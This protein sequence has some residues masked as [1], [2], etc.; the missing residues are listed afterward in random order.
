MEALEADLRGFEWRVL[1]ERS[2]GQ[3]TYA[4]TNLARPPVAWCFHKDGPHPGLRRPDGI[5][6][7]DTTERRYLGPFPGPDPGPPNGDRA[8][9]GST[10]RT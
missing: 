6:L 3:E 9:T 10:A 8:P 5:H 7:W 2:R 1:W 4:F